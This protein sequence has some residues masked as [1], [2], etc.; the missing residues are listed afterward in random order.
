M[1][2]KKKKEKMGMAKTK[3]KARPSAKRLADRKADVKAP[4]ARAR[5]ASGSYGGRRSRG[6]GK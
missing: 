2:K 3:V 1:A 5:K 6:T 4:S